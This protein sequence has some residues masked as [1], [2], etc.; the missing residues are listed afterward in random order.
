MITLLGVSKL[1][2]SGCNVLGRGICNHAAYESWLILEGCQSENYQDF[3]LAWTY[4][5]G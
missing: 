2:H 5:C 3:D 4:I 1:F